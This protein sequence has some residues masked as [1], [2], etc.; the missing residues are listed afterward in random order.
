MQRLCRSQPG[1]FNKVETIDLHPP[2]PGD[3]ISRSQPGPFN[4]VELL[5]KCTTTQLCKSRSQP[6]PFNK[7]ERGGNVLAQKI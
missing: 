1:P 6:G 2:K 3:V 7:V 5:K 4:K